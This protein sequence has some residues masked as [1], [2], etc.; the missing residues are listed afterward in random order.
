MKYSCPIYSPL[1]NAN[2]EIQMI[3][4]RTPAVW[5]SAVKLLVDCIRK[6]G[7]VYKDI[8]FALGP[9]VSS[10]LVLQRV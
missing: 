2:T 7:R 10:R 9:Y 5:R 4:T 6:K 3:C 1:R 8:S